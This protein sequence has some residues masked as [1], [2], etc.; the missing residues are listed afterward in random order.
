[1]PLHSFLIRIYGSFAA[2]IFV[3]LA[4]FMVGI[5][6]KKH[7]PLY[8]LFRAIEILV[9]AV[10]ID[11]LIWRIVPFT[12]FDV[13]YLT[14]LGILISSI[15]FK[16]DVRIRI[17]FMMIFFVLGPILQHYVGYREGVNEHSLVDPESPPLPSGMVWWFKS[18]LVD[19][20]FPVFPWVG[21][22]LA[23]S[24]VYSHGAIF[25]KMWRIFLPL[26][27]LL[28]FS[29]LTDLY[30]YRP[31]ADREFYSEL[32][33]PPGIAYLCAALGAITIGVT[34]MQ[35]LKPRYGLQLLRY[36]GSAS[37]FVYIVHSAII[38]FVLDNY[39][40]NYTLNGFLALYAC[41]AAVMITMCG[42]LFELKKRAWWKKLPW[43]LHFLLGG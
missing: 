23:G 42:I 27:M 39:C 34:M 24:L 25:S 29:G 26:G 7:P 4:G 36:L 5:G 22:A 20:W 17:I 31:I 1:V 41:F 19:G 35:F 15:L 40:T 21:F 33:Y 28:F 6:S 43:P 3:F 2:P 32:F 14:A 13:L 11:W 10:L 12:T 37:L 9:V 18:W 8:F 16:A 30:F 38:A